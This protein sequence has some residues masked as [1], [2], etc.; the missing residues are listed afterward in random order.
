[1]YSSFSAK[2]LGLAVTLSPLLTS[3]APAPGPASPPASQ[4]RQLKQAAPTGEGNVFLGSVA[5]YPQQPDL[6]LATISNNSTTNYAILAK[7]NLF[8]DDHPF[9]PISVTTLSGKAVPLVG[10]RHPYPGIEDTQFKAFPV[11]AVWERYFNMSQYIPASSEIT[12]PT[13]QCFAFA[14][15][16]MVETLN[17][18]IAKPGQYLA[19]LFLTNGITQVTVESNPMHMNVTV[20][21]AMGTATAATPTQSLPA[22]A[23]GL[24]L[25]PSEQTGSIADLLAGTYD[26]G[27]LLDDNAFNIGSSK[28]S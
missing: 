8:D 5:W 23:S 26:Q 19:D 16:K 21:P 3:G 4:R 20:A 10:S 2:L 9:A 24:I 22:V 28:L 14:L 7:N 6:L 12:I 11:G 27:D 15:P 1:M 18:D 13:S 25:S 17:L